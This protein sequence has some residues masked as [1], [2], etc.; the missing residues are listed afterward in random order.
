MRN[1][2]RDAKK[3]LYQISTFKFVEK[4]LH[5]CTA[6]AKKKKPGKNKF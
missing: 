6:R 1:N 4:Y 2:A 3:N 5:G